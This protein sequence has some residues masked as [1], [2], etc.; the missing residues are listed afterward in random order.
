MPDE[1]VGLVDE[2]KVKV[3]GS[4]L[5]SE[6]RD[7]LLECT[8][9]QSMNMPDMCVFKIHDDELKFTDD[10]LFA[11]GKPLEVEFSAQE[12]SSV[13]LFRGEI[14]A[15]EPEFGDDF[16]TLFVVRGYSKSWR[17]YRNT[18]RKTMLDQKDSDVASQVAGSMG[19]S[20][21]VDATTEVFK[22]LFQDNQSDLE[23]LQERAYRIG[24]K[25]FTKDGNLHFKKADAKIG[26]EPT[27]DWGSNLVSFYP[28]L[29]GAEQVSKVK[30]Q[31]WDAKKKEAIVGE[32][33]SSTTHPSINV[34]GSG[35][36]VT[37]KAFSEAELLVTDIPVQSV[38]DANKVAQGQLDHINGKFVQAE[39]VA[40][41]VP[42]IAAGAPVKIQKVGDKFS[43]T[44]LVTSVSHVYNKEGL[45]SYFSVKG[46][47][48]GTFTE[49]LGRQ[50][51]IRR[52]HGLYPAIVTNNKSPEN[53]WG[54]VKVKFPWLDD[55]L[56]SYWA[57][58]VSPGAGAERGFYLLPEVNDEV[59]VAFEQGDFNRPYVI[60]GLWNGKDKPP[61]PIGEVVK[62]ADVVH[63]IW[64][65]RYGNYILLDDTKGQEKIEIYSVKGHQ[66][67]FDDKEEGI[68]IKSSSGVE[69][70]IDKSSNV[71]LKNAQDL[72]VSANGNMKFDAKGNIDIKATGNLTAEA[73][74]NANFKG[75][76][77]VV[78]GQAKAE[79]KAPTVSVSGS[80]LTE[81]KGALVKIN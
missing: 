36:A 30:V 55:S 41:T 12:G 61:E 73:T 8:V 16:Q 76:Q 52:W 58:L 42:T 21:Q 53:D 18:T 15:I 74:G 4:L 48:T 40:E 29:T 72:T 38:A 37:K 43:G 32:A 54:M 33:T 9:E 10:S 64:K 62:G 59:M 49:L 35:A 45:R 2:V 78:E 44:Y 11:L 19:L 6:M 63:R 75:A 17:G 50:E 39:G 27:L 20:P 5:P 3:N 7:N 81:V 1:E 14:T 79:L 77:A 51:S 13:P 56:E 69:I 65:S 60:G 80:A 70:K 68:T 34:G 67:I 28:R 25:V 47:S 46:N 26:S 23:Y 22:Q 71:T 31:G 24:H 57:R 66:V